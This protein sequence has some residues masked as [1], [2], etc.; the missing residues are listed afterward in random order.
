M[1][2]LVYFANHLILLVD[3]EVL[4][5]L[6]V[7][8]ITMQLVVYFAHLRVDLVVLHEVLVDLITILL[9]A[10][11]L[12]HLKIQQ[13][14]FDYSC[15]LQMTKSPRRRSRTRRRLSLRR[16]PPRIVIH[17]SRHSIK[18]RSPR[19]IRP[20][21]RRLYHS[22]VGKLR[23]A[24]KSPRRSPRRPI[25]IKR[26]V[27]ER[28]E[29]QILNQIRDYAYG[30]IPSRHS[31]V[32]QEVRMSVIPACSSDC[33][34]RHQVHSEKYLKEHGWRF[35]TRKAGQPKCQECGEAVVEGYTRCP[36]CIIPIKFVEYSCLHG[37][38]RKVQEWNMIMDELERMER[39]IQEL[40]D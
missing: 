39:Q 8:L 30:D 32:Q 9:V 15:I 28:I 2:L 25:T 12:V 36:K 34:H 38:C 21:P 17:K 4:H 18:G 16:S 27:Y 40:E 1:P 23:I 11:G 37:K 14:N 10:V 26:S 19:R 20:V 29:P 3:L 31:K 35:P 6:H 7:D 33:V 13:K 5:V 24:S 22:P